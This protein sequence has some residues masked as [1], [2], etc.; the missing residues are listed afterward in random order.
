MTLQ[1][2][3]KLNSSTDCRFEPVRK[4]PKKMEIVKGIF[5]NILTPIYGPQ[6]SAVEKIERAQN[7]TCRLLYE[8]ASPKGLLVHKDQPSNECTQYGGVP[9]SLEIKTLLVI[10][11][12]KNS[13]KGFGSQLLSRVFDKARE[14]NAHAVHVTVSESK[15]DAL[16]FFKKHSFEV[17]QACNDRYKKGVTEYVLQ[18]LLPSAQP[19]VVPTPPPVVPTP[20]PARQTIYRDVTL[21]HPYVE[22]IAKG[23]KTIEGRINAGMFQH[24]KPGDGFRFF[25]HK[26]EVHCH[27]TTIN[28]YASFREMLCQEGFEKCLPEAPTLEQATAV[29]DRIPGYRER[30]AQSGV[31]ALHLAVDP[32]PARPAAA[33]IVDRKR[34]RE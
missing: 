2:T 12:E 28:S 8:G 9:N 15:P 21:K 10:D 4:D 29:Y 18:K 20:P 22:E 1:I 17:I 31:V 5:Q 30:A 33:Q 24:V 25:N 13:G 32:K 7:R 3:P 11:P 23:R 14:A 16:A 34:P 26:G 6:N 19:P 27:I